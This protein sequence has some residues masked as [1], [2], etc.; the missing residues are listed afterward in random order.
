MNR[1]KHIPAKDLS[2]IEKTAIKCCKNKTIMEIYYIKKDYPNGKRYEIEPYEIK[3]G[4][5]YAFHPIDNTIKR[6]N[7]GGIVQV[8]VLNKK[9]EVEEG[10]ERENFELKLA[11]GEDD[12]KQNTAR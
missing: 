8:G 2:H 10:H 12:E 6:F 3:N 9:W 1:N 7:L 11:K 4:G 5:L